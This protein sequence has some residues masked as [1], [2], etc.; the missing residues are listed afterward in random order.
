MVMF[1]PPIQPLVPTVDATY[2]P[3][4]EILGLGIVDVK[5]LGPIH[6]NPVILDNEEAMICLV[7]AAQSTEPSVME[8][9]GIAVSLI[10]CAAPLVLQL[11]GAVTSTK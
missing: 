2:V 10:T 7:P 11:L 4:S 6:V 9:L 8:T 1:C 3:A 5:P